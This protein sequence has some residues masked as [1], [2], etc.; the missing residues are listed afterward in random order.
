MLN[1]LD[2]F[3]GIGGFSLGL[4]RAGMRTVGFCENNLFCRKVLSKHWPEVYCYE[5]IK[6]LTAYAIRSRGITV[7]VICGGFPCQSFSKASRGEG[8]I[9]EDLWP[10]MYRIVHAIRPKWVIAEN[11]DEE[12]IANA[13]GGLHLAGYGTYY[14]RISAVECGADHMRNRWWLVAHSNPEGEFRSFVDAEV[15]KLPELCKGLW[16]AENYARAIRVPDGVSR[17][18][19]RRRIEA[20]GNA[21]IPQIPEAIGSA[22]LEVELVRSQEVIFGDRVHG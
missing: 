20:L 18:M 5:D 16:G 21:V 8:T 14:K 6:T 4:S 15:A 13:A 1:V 17:G 11:V 3:S 9:A 22:I 19:D 10:E 7:D 2:L 12:A